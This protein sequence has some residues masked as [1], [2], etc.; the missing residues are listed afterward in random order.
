MLKALLDEQALYECEHLRCVFSGGEALPV[1]A[2]QRF[3]SRMR[4]DLFNQ[5]GPTE[6]TIDATYWDCKRESTCMTTPIGRPIANKQIYILDPHL[7]PVPV[8]VPGE[9]HIGGRALPGDTLIG[10]SKLPKS[11]SSIPSLTSPVHGCT[12][13]GTSL[14][15]F[16]TG[17]LSSWG[18]SIDR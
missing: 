8:G 4:A 1:E 12:G 9:L 18:G 2:R 15:I 16:L 6:V 10:Q 3:L 17:L 14:A 7:Q 5:Y 11:S 13:Q